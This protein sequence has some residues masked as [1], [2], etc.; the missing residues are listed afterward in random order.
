MAQRILRASI[1]P[2]SKR[3]R[4]CACANALQYAILTD[5]AAI[6]PKAKD[7]LAA[8]IGKYIS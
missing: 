7:D 2:S 4:D 5:R 8:L 3:K 6:P 1:G